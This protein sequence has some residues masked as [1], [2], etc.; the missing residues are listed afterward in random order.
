MATTDSL[1]DLTTGIALS[2][3][4][5][6][7]QDAIQITRRLGIKY[8]WIDCF[9]IIQDDPKDWEREAARMAQIYRY[10]YATLS[11]MASKDSHT[12][13][14]PQR[15]Q[16]SY[17]SPGTKSLGYDNA[18]EASGPRSHVVDYEHTSWPRQRNRIHIFEEWLPGSSYY[19]PQRMDI[20]NFGK[21][22]DPLADQPLSARGWTLQERLLSPRTIHYASDQIYFECEDA[23][24]S[25]DGF[26]FPYLYFSMESLLLTQR[27]AFE[28]HGSDTAFGISF[29][30][31]KDPV[32]QNPGLRWK[33]GWLSLVE[34]YSGRQLSFSKDKLSA[35]AG[36]ARMLAEKTGDK[37]LAGLWGRHIY[38]DL[39]WRVYIREE[40]FDTSERGI[41]DRPVKGK[42]IGNAVRP[43]E[44]RAPSWSWASIDAQV[45]FI[46]LSYSFLVAQVK[47]CYTVPAGDDEFGRVCNGRLD[48]QVR[49]S[50]LPN[51]S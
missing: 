46:P 36:V 21:R 35:V 44:Y 40:Y 37:Y 49:G 3:L 2:L 29:V 33:G 34:N 5:K 4:P 26:K 18:R 39:C 43:A 12:G 17:V 9:C 30:E 20:Q 13:C 25:E 15:N 24:L 48:I 22:F 28:Q 51:F 8:L 45:K 27:C 11:A 10:S 19:V 6:T 47:E 14:F 42:E 7:F 23:I 38:E 31:G 50:T 1:D 32:S 16:D 41:A